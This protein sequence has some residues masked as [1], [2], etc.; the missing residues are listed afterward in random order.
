MDWLTTG[1]MLISIGLECC[2]HACRYEEVELL[3]EGLPH[4]V[5]IATHVAYV[6]WLARIINRIGFKSTIMD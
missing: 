3:V 1:F 2:V 6:V 4:L 5:H